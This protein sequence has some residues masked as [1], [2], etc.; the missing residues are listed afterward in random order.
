MKIMSI[1]CLCHKDMTS[2]M[3]SRMM[4]KWTSYIM[5]EMGPTMKKELCQN[6]KMLITLSLIERVPIGQQQQYQGEC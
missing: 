2:T 4:L 5:T 3:M 1:Y 6:I